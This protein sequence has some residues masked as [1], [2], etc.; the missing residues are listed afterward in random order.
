MTTVKIKLD[1]REI[2]KI[3]NG[4]DKNTDDVLG[5]LAHQGEAYTKEW[6][7]RKKVVDTGAFFNSI[8]A[9]RIRRNLWHWHDEVEYGIYQEYGHHGGKVP[10]RPTFTP[11]AEKVAR[12]LNNGR[13]WARIFGLRT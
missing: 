12:D 6:I 13:T 1:T 5:I 9:K 10:A 3:A 4:L 2:D 7:K 8:Q 11:A